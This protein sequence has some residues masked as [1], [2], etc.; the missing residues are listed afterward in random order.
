MKYVD[1]FNLPTLIGIFFVI[2]LAIS[3]FT[4]VMPSI[5]GSIFF[6]LLII[7]SL[8]CYIGFCFIIYLR[9]QF[10]HTN[11]LLTAAVCCILVNALVPV[12]EFYYENS[13]FKAV[14]Y[15]IDIVAMFF[16]LKFLISA[17]PQKGDKLFSDYL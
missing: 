1:V 5:E 11:Y 13:L 14:I 12:Q 3:V 4:L 7:V 2:Y 6:A 17:K 10:S 9:N 15:S 8:F 16:Y